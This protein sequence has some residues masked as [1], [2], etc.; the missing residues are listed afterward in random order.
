MQIGRAETISELFD[1]DN[2]IAVQ[3]EH[4]KGLPQEC[5]VEQESLG[6][7]SLDEFLEPD[8]TIVV[9][10]KALEELVK[11]DLSSTHV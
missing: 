2:A 10:V 8:S 1:A 4:V 5:A 6:I 9:S 7:D 11:V 3:I